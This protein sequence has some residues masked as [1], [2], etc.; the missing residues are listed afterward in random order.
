LVAVAI[1]D[2]MLGKS[3]WDGT[4]RELLEELKVLAGKA[5]EDKD[6]PPDATRLSERLTRLA[7]DLRQVGIDVQRGR[8]RK[9]GR[10]IVLKQVK[11]YQENAEGDAEGDASFRTASPFNP[12]KTNKGDA[13]DA[14]DAKI[15]TQSGSP[16][17][18]GLWGREAF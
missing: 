2:F 5:V 11:S 16:P 1:R 9:T 18:D 3:T 4:T 15:R 6:W 8:R 12:L 17:G 13:G 14:G 7:S 10:K